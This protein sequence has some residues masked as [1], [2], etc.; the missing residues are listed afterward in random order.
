MS[1]WTEGE[2]AKLQRKGYTAAAVVFYNRIDTGLAIAF[3]AASKFKQATQQV[4]SPDLKECVVG[5]KDEEDG[6]RIRRAV[7][8][9]REALDRFSLK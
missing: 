5:V 9:G 2:A 7:K 3:L 4:V 8:V 6:S 1:E